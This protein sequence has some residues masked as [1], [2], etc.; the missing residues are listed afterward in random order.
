MP[1]CRS[2]PDVF[3][4]SGTSKRHVLSCFLTHAQNHW[5]TLRLVT[6]H[7]TLQKCIVRSAKTIMFIVFNECGRKVE[8]GHVTN[9]CKNQ[10]LVTCGTTSQRHFRVLAYVYGVLA[11]WRRHSE[12]HRFTL[13]FEANTQ[14]HTQ[15]SS[16]AGSAPIPGWPRFQIT[17][18]LGR[19]P[20]PF[21][22][23]HSNLLCFETMSKVYI[24]R[25]F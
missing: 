5:K 18:R 22:P 13:A 9:H 20:P 23:L 12:N 6:C 19:G 2:L 17:L 7:H 4:H 1:Q 10:W 21:F 3:Q 11:H 14:T 24:S 16:P 25:T 8:R 15:R